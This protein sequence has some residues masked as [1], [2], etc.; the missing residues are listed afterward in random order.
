MASHSD[1]VRAWN[2]VS[3][4]RSGRTKAQSAQV[5]DRAARR[6]GSDSTAPARMRA[7]STAKPPRCVSSRPRQVACNWFAGLQH[8]RDAPRPAAMDDAGMAAMGAGE[9]VEDRRRLGMGPDRQDDALV[10]PFHRRP[11]RQPVLVQQVPSARILDVQH[12]DV[13]V[14]TPPGATRRRRTRPPSPRRGRSRPGPPSSGRR[15][16]GAARPARPASSISRGPRPRSRRPGARPCRECP[17]RP[18]RIR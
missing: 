7:G 11:S 10:T 8:R 15:T 14:R 6:R 9:E 3:T 12:P 16:A 5:A 18:S 17:A 4:S 1:S 2:A 13:R